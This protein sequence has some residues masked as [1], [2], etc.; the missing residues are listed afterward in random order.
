MAWIRS[1]GISHSGKGTQCYNAKFCSDP[2]ISLVIMVRKS[3]W[4]KQMMHCL[5]VILKYWRSTPVEMGMRFHSKTKTSNLGTNNLVP[6]MIFLDVS[7]FI[8]LLAK[9][10]K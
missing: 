8:Y 5:V 9:S 6:I 2:L 7:L 10:K 4:D 3:D 1:T